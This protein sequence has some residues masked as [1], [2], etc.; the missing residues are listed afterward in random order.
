MQCK[1]VPVNPWRVFILDF[2]F[3]VIS[4]EIGILFRNKVD[5]GMA[6][7]HVQA[8]RCT[9]PSYIQKGRQ[10]LLF[11]PI[12]ATYA[13]VGSSVI[14][15]ILTSHALLA[16]RST[17]MLDGCAWR[18][19]QRNGEIVLG[20]ASPW[21]IQWFIWGSWTGWL[22]NKGRPNTFSSLD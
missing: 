6:G 1:L 19:G 2:R 13:Q 11:H 12:C 17:F 15:L 5:S 7:D 14:I 18:S 20:I 22:A 9:C 3:Y 10:H 4:L 21:L 8:F 16:F